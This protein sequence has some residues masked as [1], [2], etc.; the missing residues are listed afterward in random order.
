MEWLREAVWS[1]EPAP[2]QYPLKSLDKEK[3]DRMNYGVSGCTLQCQFE[4]VG[5]ESRHWNT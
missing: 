1:S 4:D 5:K 2:V 3:E